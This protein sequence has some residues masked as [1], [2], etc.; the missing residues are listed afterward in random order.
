MHGTIKQ[1]AVPLLVAEPQK[2]NGRATMMQ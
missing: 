2:K 1:A